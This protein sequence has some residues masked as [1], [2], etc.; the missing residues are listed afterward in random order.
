MPRQTFKLNNKPRVLCVRKYHHSFYRAFQD[1][2]I[3][4]RLC[5]NRTTK[6][7]TQNKQILFSHFIYIESNQHTSTPCS[8]CA[9]AKCLSWTV[10]VTL[11]IVLV[12]LNTL[13]CRIQKVLDTTLMLEQI[14]SMLN[15][16]SWVTQQRPNHN[17]SPREYT[18]QTRCEIR[19]KKSRQPLFGFNVLQS[20]VSSLWFGY[21]MWYFYVA[22]FYYTTHTRYA[23]IHRERNAFNVC[24]F[25]LRW[26]YSVESQ[27]YITKPHT[28]FGAKCVGGD[29]LLF[30]WCDKTVY[31]VRIVYTY[32]F[33]SYVYIYIYIYKIVIKV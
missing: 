26:I 25:F 11:Y 5:T 20:R 19:D 18:H 6:N 2:Q 14:C 29:C 9:R 12:H 22:F 30:I 21:F 3:H 10:C 28:Y 8:C 32:V 31:I 7:A 17:Q 4:T 1:I 13:N 15:G 23:V 24:L 27:V 33:C 16:Q